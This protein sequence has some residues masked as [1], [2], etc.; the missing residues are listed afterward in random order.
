[1][2]EFEVALRTLYDASRLRNAT[3]SFNESLRTAQLNW[4]ELECLDGICMN[5][6]HL[7]LPDLP[8]QIKVYCLALIKYRDVA[9]DTDYQYAYRYRI[10]YKQ[11]AWT[12][13]VR[14]SDY[15]DLYERLVEAI[16]DITDYEKRGFYE[17]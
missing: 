8:K 10:V 1:M 2:D 14:D 9:N 16:K 13:I 11:D 7:N 3:L 15:S 17:F 6:Y 12:A 5:E 4:K